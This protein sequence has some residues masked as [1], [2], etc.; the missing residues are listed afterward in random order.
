[1]RF[2][3]ALLETAALGIIF[4]AIVYGILALAAWCLKGLMLAP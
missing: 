2:I 4:L 1:M 3:D